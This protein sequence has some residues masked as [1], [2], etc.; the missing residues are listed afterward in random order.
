MAFSGVEESLL[1][2][3]AT[4][5]VME[6]VFGLDATHVGQRGR[7]PDVEVSSDN[8]VGIIDT[9]AYAAYDLPSDHQL[10]M[11]TSYVPK[12][13]SGD[14]ELAFFMYVAGGFAPSINGKLSKVID[15][16]GIPGSGIGIVPWIQLI[17]GYEDSGL[18]RED[19]R[20]L[21]SIG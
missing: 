8:W 16:T 21:W 15:A 19:L 18:D 9:K 13:L 20:E 12:D 6:N 3:Q 11:Q 10:R 4:A 7:V 5:N 2:E 17:N 1:F 14:S